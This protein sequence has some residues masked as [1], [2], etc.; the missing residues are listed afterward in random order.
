MHKRYKP[1]I[2][3]SFSDLLLYCELSK[4]VNKL[5]SFRI[6]VPYQ[7]PTLFFKANYDINN[8][9]FEFFQFDDSIPK[10]SLPA[11]SSTFAL[12]AQIDDYLYVNQ[13]IENGHLYIEGDD[14][15]SLRKY[16]REKR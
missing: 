10:Y 6:I 14:L 12:K 5:S 11:N 2:V 3:S 13:A 8:E 7:E 15:I 9:T 4:A 1:Q 16:K